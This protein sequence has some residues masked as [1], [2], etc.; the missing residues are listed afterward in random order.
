MS[1][2]CHT[3]HLISTALRIKSQITS[4]VT[5]SHMPCLSDFFDLILYH[6]VH[7]SLISNHIQPS[8]CFLC[9]RFWKRLDLSSAANSLLP[10][11]QGLTSP[12]HYDVSPNVSL[13]AR[14]YQIML[15]KLS[16]IRYPL[17]LVYLS[18]LFYL[19][20]LLLLNIIACSFWLCLF[21]V[22]FLLFHPL[23][24]GTEDQ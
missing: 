12:N 14:S 19:K 5:S 16:P 23:P 13:Q 20:H 8:L 7:R 24:A 2:L 3:L 17:S 1:H 9:S 10:E 6:S 15:P 4:K 22:C 18:I 21:I 11:P